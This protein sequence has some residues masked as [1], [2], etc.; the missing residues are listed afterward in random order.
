M[1]PRFM[2]TVRARQSRRL[3]WPITHSPAGVKNDGESRKLLL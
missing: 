3:S 1:A 2:Q